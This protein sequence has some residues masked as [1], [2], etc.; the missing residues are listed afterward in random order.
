[1]LHEKL[2]I[3]GA[4]DITK[5]ELTTNQIGTDVYH[6]LIIGSGSLTSDITMEDWYN[7][8]YIGEEEYVDAL[9]GDDDTGD[10]SAGNPFE[11]INKAMIDLQNAGTTATNKFAVIHLAG[12]STYT[13]DVSETG[14]NKIS[15][16]SPAFEGQGIIFA[17]E[18]GYTPTIKTQDRSYMNYSDETPLS[19][20]NIIGIF[21]KDDLTWAAYDVAVI[22]GPN[23]GVYYLNEY[24]NSF[25]RS[26]M[27]K[28][29]IETDNQNYGGC[30]I[31]DDKIVIVTTEMENNDLPFANRGNYYIRAFTAP[32]NALSDYDILSDI[33]LKDMRED[34]YP[35]RNRNIVNWMNNALTGVS[36]ITDESGYLFWYDFSLGRYRNQRLGTAINRAT[37]ATVNDT[38]YFNTEGSIYKANLK[39]SED[40]KEYLYLT[41]C[42]TGEK[43][44]NVTISGI[45]NG[46]TIGNVIVS[47]DDRVLLTAQT[48]ATEN[49]IYVVGAT[50]GTT[51]R[52]TDFDPTDP[53]TIRYKRVDVSSGTN[54]GLTFYTTDDFIQSGDDI[55]FTEG[56]PDNE[57]LDVVQL[58]SIPNVVS[59]DTRDTTGEIYALTST[60][61]VWYCAPPTES[62]IFSKIVQLDIKRDWINIQIKDDGIWTFNG[63]FTAD[64]PIAS[65]IS[66]DYG[67]YRDGVL[68]EYG[69]FF[70]MYED[71]AFKFYNY[72]KE[73][74]LS[75]TCGRTLTTPK[76]ILT[77]NKTI[78]LYDVNIDGNNKFSGINV[79]Y[80]VSKYSKITN[81]VNGL[82]CYNDNGINPSADSLTWQYSISKSLF[83]NISGTAV[84]MAGNIDSDSNNPLV[85]YNIFND[86][87]LGVSIQDATGLTIQ[88]I[89]KCV[90]YN[91]TVG[92]NVDGTTNI[93]NTLFENCGTD[94]I[95]NVIIA[96]QSLIRRYFS[97]NNTYQFSEIYTGNPG[98]VD[99][100]NL[101][102]RLK[103]TYNSYAYDSPYIED[104]ELEFDEECGVY[105][106]TR[107]STISDPAYEY[108]I[109]IMWDELEIK[110]TPVLTKS[111]LS[112]TGEYVEWSP[113]SGTT[114][115]QLN[116]SWN[117]NTSDANSD[118]RRYF[119]FVFTDLLNYRD[120][121]FKLGFDDGSDG[122]KPIFTFDNIQHDTTKNGLCAIVSTTNTIYKNELRGLWIYIP[123]LDDYML[124]LSNTT[125]D[126]GTFDVE[127]YNDRGLVLTGVNDSNPH[128]D[129][130]HVVFS[131]ESGQTNK[132]W[133]FF[134]NDTNAPLPI[135]GYKLIA[136]E[137][138]RDITE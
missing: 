87:G 72:I 130:W 51:V 75:N 26:D 93:T 76:Y 10:G 54:A 129:Y 33:S 62:E 24:K 115:K 68:I 133:K 85:D 83:D 106:V 57:I 40:I 61:G 58:Q 4:Y 81:I 70:D 125:T 14:S 1:M 127:L 73:A 5:S 32:S 38:L 89:N 96:N 2:R 79:P 105:L 108:I 55:N 47:T 97:N 135:A 63:T 12:N 6:S 27:T 118:T 21:S 3:V 11:T 64:I 45:E 41:P 77:G 132:V 117:D 88:N 111:T 101:D 74:N 71:D 48:D 124:I 56:Y 134:N 91:N 25:N 123:S 7:S 43:A 107:T 116:F 37:F 95:A 13:I 31:V 82:Y 99:P 100:D 98:F 20:D 110:E 119:K 53:S 137:T 18:A 122:W 121:V 35:V 78:Y 128:C 23:S 84:Y 114:K 103:T 29:S 39:N 60:G 136:H 44:I 66:N 46:D 42:K 16:L 67:A 69:N 131:M 86:C 120:T 8:T 36:I 104:G 9:N 126:S 113:N 80:P 94:I 65:R 50:A 112:P 30:T 15:T 52:S 28:I 59:I 102:F 49:G 109:P 17:G 19:T 34:T 90:F 138:W 92:L 22:A